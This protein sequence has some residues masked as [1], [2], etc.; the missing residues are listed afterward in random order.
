MFLTCTRPW[1]QNSAVE[2]GPGEMAAVESVGYVSMRTRFPTPRGPKT[3]T[4]HYG[5][6]AS[7]L[8]ENK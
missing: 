5:L 4:D 1:I 6:L 2:A 7:R 3:G 8:A